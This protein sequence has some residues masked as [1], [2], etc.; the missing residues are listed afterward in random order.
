MADLELQVIEKDVIISFLSKQL[1]NKNRNNDSY[2]NT[3]VNDY[4]NTFHERVEIINNN[5]SLSQANKKDKRKNVI[6][7]G[8]SMLNNK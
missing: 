2:A 3:T 1:I 6:I 5:L 7:V 4:N 8:D